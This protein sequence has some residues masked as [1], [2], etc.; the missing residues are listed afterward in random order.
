MFYSTSRIP[1][2]VTY[3]IEILLKFFHAGSGPEGRGRAGG[4]LIIFYNRVNG[5]VVRGTWGEIYVCS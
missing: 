2:Q 1:I 3:E 4:C 5:K